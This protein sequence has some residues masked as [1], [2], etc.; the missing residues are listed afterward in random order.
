VMV[1]RRSGPIEQGSRVCLSDERIHLVEGGDRPTEK[2]KEN[3]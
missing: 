1:R 2:G 3:R